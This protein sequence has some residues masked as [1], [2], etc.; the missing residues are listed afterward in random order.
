MT[1]LGCKTV[2][3]NTP[4]SYYSDSP[5]PRLAPCGSVATRGLSSKHGEEL[6]YKTRARRGGVK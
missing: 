2:S 4:P 5:R 1:P 3:V 6:I